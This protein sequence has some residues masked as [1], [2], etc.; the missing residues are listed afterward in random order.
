MA[1]RDPLALGPLSSFDMRFVQWLAEDYAGGAFA[2]VRLGLRDNFE[3]VDATVGGLET[4]SSSF[5]VLVSLINTLTRFYFIA[6][7]ARWTDNS[8]Y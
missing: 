2:F 8:W 4:S 5:D 1:P 6:R 7:G 3:L